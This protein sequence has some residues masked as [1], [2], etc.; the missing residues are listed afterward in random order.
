MNYF[1]S[2]EER[3]IK[4]YA[5][6]FTTKFILPNAIKWDEEGY[7][8]QEII[9][10]EQYKELA[11]VFIPKDYGG[12]GQ[13]VFSLVLVLEELSYGCAGVATT[14][15]AS[16][17]AALPLINFGS[18]EQKG[19]YLPLLLEGKLS[20][21]ALTEPEA[22]SD[23][24]GINTT[25]TRIDSETYEINGLKQWVTNGGKAGFYVIV[26][27]TEREKGARGASCF[28]LDKD[29]P[30]LM[31]TKFEN[32]LGIRSSITAEIRLNS[33]KVKKEALLGKEGRGFMIVID[34]LNRSRPGVGA[35]AIGIAQRA[36][37][38]A[39]EY[40]TRRKQFDKPISSFQGIQFSLADLATKIEAARALV[41]QAARYID[42]GAKDIAKEAAMAK[43]F[44]SQVAEEAASTALQI[45]GGYGYMKDSEVE[46]LYRDAK[47]TQI[48]EGT[49]EIQ[50]NI[51]S[52][53]L[54]KEELS[55]SK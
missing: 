43:L 51:I 42:S 28:L 54:I 52:N 41:Y 4:E 44:A 45:F 48:Y 22:G 40:S 19:N 7:F 38:L 47:I 34:T 55:K 15:A 37:D 49:S 26:A 27:L 18:S 46:K 17:L 6:D 29:T 12:L 23:A 5:K 33:C 2:E 35:I 8:P 31:V 1:L 36:L 50:R 20:A 25:A 11:G 13:G 14:Y 10:N 16:V 9:G 30:G 21:F 3:L 24:A 39:V 32:K 53:S